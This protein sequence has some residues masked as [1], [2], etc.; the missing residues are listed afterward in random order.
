MNQAEV[1]NR[2]EQNF[3]VSYMNI[4]EVLGWIPQEIHA[5]LWTHM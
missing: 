2:D 5:C 3:I 1:T 4:G